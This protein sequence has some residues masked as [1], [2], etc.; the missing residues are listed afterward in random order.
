MLL[1]V[2]QRTLPAGVAQSLSVWLLELIAVLDSHHTQV[3]IT[4][5]KER[6]P[7]SFKLY[8]SHFQAGILKHMFPKQDCTLLELKT[9][10]VS[11][12][13]SQCVLDFSFICLESIQYMTWFLFPL[14]QLFLC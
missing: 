11:I 5:E 4:T 10:H 9:Q 14:Y 7:V 1:E 3:W 6:G 12:N 8:F 2:H 13:S